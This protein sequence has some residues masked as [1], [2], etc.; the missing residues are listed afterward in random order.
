MYKNTN[1]IK[2]YLVWQNVSQQVFHYQRQTQILET[3]KER[4][5]EHLPKSKTKSNPPPLLPIL[6]W[7][8]GVPVFWGTV[9]I[10]EEGLKLPIVEDFSHCN[11]K[12][13]HKL[14]ISNQLVIVVYSF[15]CFFFFFILIS[16]SSIGPIVFVN[17]PHFLPFL[18]S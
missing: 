2:S 4:E 3:K 9:C 15:S 8:F 1:S 17:H 13:N 12:S 11:N 6:L 18:L 7:Y 5:K 10:D 16:Y 14:L